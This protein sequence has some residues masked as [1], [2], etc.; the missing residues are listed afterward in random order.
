MFA[1]LNPGPT[2]L[3]KADVREGVQQ[4][5]ASQAPSPATG[6]LVYAAVQPSLVLLQVKG[7]G[8]ANAAN[9]GIGSGVVVSDQGDILTALHVVVERDHDHG[10]VR[11]RLDARRDRDPAGARRTTS[12]CSRRRRCPRRSSRRPLA[13]PVPC[14]SA[15]T[16][17]VVGNP[18]GLYGSIS[19]GVVSGLERTFE[20]P[21]D[22]PDP[23]GPHPGRCRDQPGHSGGALLNR[24][25]QVVGIVTGLINPTQQNVFIG[26]G[27]AVPIDVAGGAAGLPPY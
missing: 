24:D 27:L 16:R 25:G 4:V 17:I 26:I 15:T 6:S 13:I 12:R 11:R 8:P 14:G 23:E 21:A 18:F 1:I 7:D 19:A 10:H 5:L 20:Q 22:T 3:T 2:P 9:D